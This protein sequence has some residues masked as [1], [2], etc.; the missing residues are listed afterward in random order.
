MA[1]LMLAKP[2]ARCR[3][4]G[5]TTKV[6]NQVHGR[7]LHEFLR[8]ELAPGCEWNQS[9]GF[10]GLN[11]CRLK[12][13]SICQF[14]SYE[15][16]MTAHA[17]DE[18]DACLLDEPPT[19][20]VFTEALARVFSKNGALWV[21]LTAVGRPVKWLRQIVEAGVKDRGAGRGRGWSFYQ[22]GLSAANCPW[23]DPQEIEEFVRDARRTPWNYAQR[24]EGAWD[25]ISEERRFS[26]F[27]DVN[28]L[29]A[30]VGPRQ[31]WLVPG[32]L[33]RLVL[34]VDHG[35]GAGHSHWLLLA[36]QVVRRTEYGCE[37]TIRVIGEWTN[38]KRMSA[39]KEAAA[40]REMV[41]SHGFQ[42]T[43]IEWAVGDTNTAAKSEG[44]RLLNDV[45]AAE[46]AR[47]MGLPPGQGI[48]FRPAKKGPDS[49]DA[50]LA[51]C[52]GLF[53]ERVRS[54]KTPDEIPS[55]LISEVAE[56]TVEC[57]SHWNGK[58]DGLKHGSDCLR[59]GVTAI[60]REEG[61]D[62]HQRLLAA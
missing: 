34:A 8:D 49:I 59:Y 25:G 13:G 56:R 7:Y 58:E 29:P 55:L 43:D 9:T 11:L 18:L 41:Q 16:P 21:T 36:W 35:E 19:T 3:I 50:G 2:G 40:V 57:C 51:A 22:I 23:Y 5:P 24:I 52:N 4:V 48:E 54:A 53:D 61:W 28:V 26:S 44:A 27:T 20:G 17:S 12:N 39:R 45:F 32:A 38:P 46:F 33:V 10:N 1:R 15:Q 47:L 37:L 60:T 14:M 42:L 31:G 62:P 30:D 6:V